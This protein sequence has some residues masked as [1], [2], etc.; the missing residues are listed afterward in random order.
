MLAAGQPP[1][2]QHVTAA[3]PYLPPDGHLEILDAGAAGV[4]TYEWA[5]LSGARFLTSGPLEFLTLKLDLDTIT[6][7]TWYRATIRPYR[8]GAERRWGHEYLYSPDD[9]GLQ[10]YAIAGPRFVLYDDPVLVL[11]QNLAAGAEWQDSGTARI[12]RDNKIAEVPYT[13]QGKAEA[14]ADIGTGCLRVEATEV[15]GGDTRTTRTTWC[16]G[17]AIVT[18]ADAKARDGFGDHSPNADAR[19]VA[20]TPWSDVTGWK[21]TKPELGNSV[22]VSSR[23]PPRFANGSAFTLADSLSGDLVGF[24]KGPT[25]LNARWRAHPGGQ[26]LATGQFGDVAVVATSKREL[27]AYDTYGQFLWRQPTNDLVQTDI[28]RL[29]ADRLITASLDGTITAHDIRTG[30]VEWTAKLPVE[31]RVPPVSDGSTVIVV[32]N[33]GRMVALG[34]DDGQQLWTRTLTDAADHLT[35]SGGTVGVILSLGELVEAYS[36]ESGDPQ[37]QVYQRDSPDALHPT[38][39]G[40]VVVTGVGIRKLTTAGDV[41][42]RGTKDYTSSA[43]VPG[44]GWLLVATDTDVDVIDSDGRQLA[45]WPIVTNP[46]ASDLWLVPGY[47]EFLVMGSIGEMLLVG[48]AR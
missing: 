4:I 6:K 41:A 19:I 30:N 25:Y 20:P 10:L 15:L 2:V 23:H 9:K 3:T 27:V 46:A 38:T 21:A 7:R 24:V 1:Q 48:P 26:I 43:A 33:A 37:W 36:L 35:V 29:T 18:D 8:A 5:E 16:P 45:T 31:I 39:G 34:A 22:S 28:V 40:F 32:D 17:R 14:A 42:W 11:P 12:A 13:Y 44:T 47:S